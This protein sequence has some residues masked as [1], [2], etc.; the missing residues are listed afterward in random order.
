M[1]GRIPLLSLNELGEKSVKLPN[2]YA[3][4][5]FLEMIRSKDGLN[6]CGITVKL[7]NLYVFLCGLKATVTTMRR[8]VILI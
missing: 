8:H 1:R 4:K 7:Q 5:S 2:S 3:N 6:S